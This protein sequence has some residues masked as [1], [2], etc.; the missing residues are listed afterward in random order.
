VRICPHRPHRPAACYFVAFEINNQSKI[1]KDMGADKRFT[2]GRTNDDVS[3]HHFPIVNKQAEPIG[4]FRDATIRQFQGDGPGRLYPNRLRDL[5]R[6]PGPSCSGIYKKRDL[7]LA[8]R[9][10]DV[11]DGKR[12]IAIAHAPAFVS[13]Q[14]SAISHRWYNNHSVIYPSHF[15]QNVTPT[16]PSPFKGEGWEGV[17]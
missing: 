3:R 15:E 17:G 13:V 16:L 8:F 9:I 6:D 14:P 7:L 12:Q 1:L 11:C 4:A 10:L 2:I 5:F